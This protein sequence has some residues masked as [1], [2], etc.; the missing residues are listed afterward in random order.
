MAHKPGEWHSEGKRIEVVTSYLILGNA[1]MVEGITGVPVGTIRRWKQE[2][3]WDDLV[4]QIQT[5]DNQELDAKISKRLNKALDVVQDRL[6]AGDFMY[7][8]KSGEFVRRPVNMKDTWKV[9]KEMVDVR[10][11]LRKQPKDQKSQ[12]AIGDILKNL[13]QEFAGMARKKV[14]D[15]T[16]L[17]NEVVEKL[18]NGGKVDAEK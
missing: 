13:A 15:A 6:E 17:Q 14:N 18:D 5:E 7:D 12:E 3:W 1:V 2:P 16:Q 9:A 11:M 8:P 4:L 10:T